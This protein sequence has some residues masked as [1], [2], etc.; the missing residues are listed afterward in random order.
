MSLSRFLHFRVLVP[1]FALPLL[2]AILCACDDDDDGS[3]SSEAPTVAAI[4]TQEN[5]TD[6]GAT[7]GGKGTDGG[8]DSSGTEVSISSRG[9]YYAKTS[10]YLI[11]QRAAPG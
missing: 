6:F 10:E 2:V 11:R 1:L 3:S 8:K 4:P 5:L 9:I 7:L